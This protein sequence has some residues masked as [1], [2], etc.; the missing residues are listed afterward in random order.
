M[1]PVRLELEAS[2][3][4]LVVHT[5]PSEEPTCVVLLPHAFGHLAPRYTGLA[6]GLAQ[7]GAVVYAPQHATRTTAEGGDGPVFD[8]EEMTSDLHVVATRARQDYPDLPLYMIG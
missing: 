5:W 4:Q 3:W 7:V 6:E 1:S 2:R 8:A